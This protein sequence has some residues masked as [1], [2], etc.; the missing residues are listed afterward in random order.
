MCMTVQGSENR[1]MSNCHSQNVFDEGKYPYYN[2][3]KS[4]N[5]NPYHVDLLDIIFYMSEKIK[6]TKHPLIFVDGP[7]SIS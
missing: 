5:Y 7:T 4:L 1:K 3:F 6:A 2:M